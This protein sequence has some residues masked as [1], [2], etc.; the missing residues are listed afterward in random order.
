MVDENVKQS[1]VGLPAGT[2][3]G[4]YEIG[5]RL[6]I[7]GQAIIY[8]A[9]DSLLGRDVA[10]KQISTHLAEDAAFLERFRKEAQILARLGQEQPAIV[11]IHELIEEERGLFIIMEFV[12]GNNLETIL[13]ENGGPIETKAALQV[14]FRL[15]GAL[16]S[17]HAAGIIHRDIKPANIMIGDGLRVKIADFGVAAS[18]TG[19]TSM[20]LG[21]TKYMAPELFTGDGPIDG[22]ADMYSLGFIAYEM[23][24]GR[25]KFKEVFSEVVRDPHTESFRW[26]K[27]HSDR[28]V[29]APLLNEVNPAVPL[30]LAQIVAKMMVK[31]PNER[32]ASMEA[33]GRD[34]KGHFSPRTR[35]EAAAPAAAAAGTAVAAPAAAAGAAVAPPV[36]QPVEDEG[37]GTPPGEAP[38]GQKADVSAEP[39]AGGPAT[40]ALPKRVIP[41]K[42]K[43]IIA[44]GAFVVVLGVV[45]GLLIYNSMKEG[46]KLTAAQMLYKQALDI[47]NEGS[48]YK[49][50]Q[51]AF[52]QVIARFPRTPEEAKASVI[53]PLCKA[54]EAVNKYEWQEAQKDEKAARDRLNEVQGFAVAKSALYTWT[55]EFKD[56]IDKFKDY[57]ILAWRFRDKLS[58]AQDLL[59]EGKFEAAL[60]E[61]EEFSRPGALPVEAFR[62]ELAVFKAKVA[63]ARFRFDCSTAISK[64][65]GLVAE[66]KLDEAKQAYLDAKALLESKQGL[67]LPKQERDK[68]LSQ[69]ASKLGSVETRGRYEDAMASAEE[70]CKDGDKVGEMAA[71]QRAQKIKPTP[72]VAARIKALR[73]E[74]D[75]ER[76]TGLIEGNPAEAIKVLKEILEYDPGNSKAKSLLKG[77]EQRAQ[78]LAVLSKA[79]ALY[80]KQNYVAALVEYEK[81]AALQAPDATVKERMLDCNYRIKVAEAERLRHDDK[82]AE[83]IKAYEEAL[84][85]R[86]DKAAWISARQELCSRELQYRAHRDAGNAAQQSKNWKSALAEYIKAQRIKNGEEIQV[87]IS[88]TKYR[89]F[90]A[91]G[92]AALN[93]ADPKSAIAYFNRAKAIMDTEEVRKLIDH[94]KKLL[95]DSK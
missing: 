76:A 54:H 53:L 13:E 88:T 95:N 52:K 90:L 20:V 92:K 46:E 12:P 14:L 60:A 11:T 29:Q 56:V 39:S 6:K 70:A 4:K 37:H 10:I 34:I 59:V 19:Q 22:R 41:L 50:A 15:A 45:L 25:E 26:M 8:K 64:G 87:L 30:P 33:L 72:E 55:Q 2:K 28:L 78:R 62:K 71:L 75:M 61:V 85:F 94:A 80:R 91:S 48:D 47:F 40:A 74:V 79:H 89:R 9:H 24:A 44:G 49:K 67:V 93:E 23:L 38:A 77:L 35:G 58:R 66:G 51:E 82:L 84:P 81:A 7:G 42:K 43:L 3:I 63:L 73:S 18:M 17:V 27:W 16:H 5:Q 65:H 83:A 1:D 31:D 68:L 32:Y 36:A 69:L 86:P 21:T 57:R